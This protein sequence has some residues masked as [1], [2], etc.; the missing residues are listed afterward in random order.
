[1]LPR[2]QLI[3]PGLRSAL[4]GPVEEVSVQEALARGEGRPL[5]TLE[6]GAEDLNVLN[7]MEGLPW[8]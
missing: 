6:A 3:G 4:G 8:M 2:A 1:M 7:P 5:L